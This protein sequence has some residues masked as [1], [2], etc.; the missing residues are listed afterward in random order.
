MTEPKIHASIKCSGFNCRQRIGQ[1][2]LLNL[3]NIIKRL[4]SNTNNINA[5]TG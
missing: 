2:N 1:T 5:I 3:L 4:T